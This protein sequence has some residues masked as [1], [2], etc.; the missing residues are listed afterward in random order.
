MRILVPPHPPQSLELSFVIS[1][2]LVKS[3]ILFCIS[4]IINEVKHLFMFTGQVGILS[5]DVT[6]KS[7]T[8]FLMSSPYSVLRDFKKY[9]RNESFFK[10]SITN[11]FT[12]SSSLSICLPL[13]YWLM[14]TKQKIN[15]FLTSLCAV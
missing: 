8:Y 6:G 9:S 13:S 5:C 15:T 10:H 14:K 2:L 1:T 7:L 11:I 4:P 12:S 3:Y